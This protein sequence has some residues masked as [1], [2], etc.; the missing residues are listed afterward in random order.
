MGAVDDALHDRYPLARARSAA[1]AATAVADF[2]FV[3]GEFRIRL[4]PGMD[5]G[6]PGAATFSGV[7]SIR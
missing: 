3:V 2:L 4:E 6:L 7:L 5:L 1:A